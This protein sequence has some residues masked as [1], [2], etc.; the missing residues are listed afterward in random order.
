MG[1]SWSNGSQFWAV[2][3]Q[4]VQAVALGDL[5]MAKRSSKYPS[6]EART[7]NKKDNNQGQWLPWPVVRWSVNRHI[8]VP[9]TDQI[10]GLSF[11]LWV[12][13]VDFLLCPVYKWNCRAQ[14]TYMQNHSIPELVLAKISGLCYVSGNVCRSS[15]LILA[16][17]SQHSA[18]C[19]YEFKYVRYWSNEIGSQVDGVRSRVP[20]VSVYLDTVPSGFTLTCQIFPPSEAESQGTVRMDHTV[21]LCWL[22]HDICVVFTSWL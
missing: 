9:F 12:V 2:R 14:N 8:R 7:P 18:F 3:L 15:F 10:V 17:G 21:F 6:D 1:S 5:D 13:I 4:S 22:L 16:T 20:F 19:A 11:W